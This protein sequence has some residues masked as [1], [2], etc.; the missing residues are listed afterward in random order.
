M[1]SD[2][3][4]GGVLVALIL[5]GWIVWMISRIVA[6]IFHD[7]GIM[8]NAIGTAAVNFLGMAWALAQLAGILAAGAAVVYAAYR[9]Y[10][11]V[12]E[13]LAVLSAVEARCNELA[14]TVDASEKELEKRLTQ[15]VALLRQQLA[16]ALAKPEVAPEE[17]KA[18]PT[19]AEVVADEIVIETA[20][21]S[22]TAPRV[23]NPY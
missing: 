2:R 11:F 22:V 1:D 8:F 12:K 20:I 18:L 6:S 13:S 15:E 10:Q 5:F 9:Y 16:L 21:E 19:P 7:L 23:S 14:N 4:W 17:P 3:I